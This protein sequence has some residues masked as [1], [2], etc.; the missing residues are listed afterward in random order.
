MRWH[1][2]LVSLKIVWFTLMLM[3]YVMPCTGQSHELDSLEQ[4]LKDTKDSPA[5]VQVLYALTNQYLLQ[6]GYSLKVIE[7]A[8]Q[9]C[10]LAHHLNDQLSIAYCW[11]LRGVIARNTSN[12][13]EA[14]EGHKKALEISTMLNHK[15]SMA[16]FLNNMGVVYR[17]VDDYQQALTFHLKALKLSE[18]IDDKPNISVAVNSIGNIYLSIKEWGKALNYLTKGLELETARSNKLGVAINL[19]NIGG[20]HENLGNF[21]KALTYYQQSLT[22]NTEM[23]NSKGIAICL[24]D[25]GNIY[26]KNNRPDEALVYYLQALEINSKLGD[27]V[28]ITDSY[29]NIGKVSSR[30]KNYTQSLQY[31]QKGLHTAQEVGSKKHIQLCFEAISDTYSQMGMHE[32][33]LQVYKKAIIYKDSLLNE[34]NAKN[35]AGLQAFFDNKKKEARIGVLE[36][37]KEDKEQKIQYQR[38]VTGVLVFGLLL[39]LVV[40]AFLYRNYHIRKRTNQ[41]LAYQN[42]AINLQKDEILR[43]KENIDLKNQELVLLNEE[44][45]HLIG[46]VAHDL[47]SPL[48]RMYGLTNLLK[49]DEKN[50][51]GEQKQY[52]QLISEESARLN[53]M[54]AKILDMNAIEQ[55]RINLKLEK[56]AVHQLIQETVNHIQPAAAKKQIRIHFSPST[57]KSFALLDWGYAIQILDNLLSNAVKFSPSG[58]QVYIDLQESTETIEITIVDEGPG[59]STEDQAK[60][61]GKFQKL[62]ARPTAGEP[63]TGLG[64]SIV[65]KYVEAMHGQIRCESTQGKGAKFI[66]SFKKYT[67]AETAVA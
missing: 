38:I 17:R 18:S 9:A 40:F 33:A 34:S 21:D 37:E 6:Q 1:R 22:L 30:L 65:K 32:Q 47:R 23:N 31:L 4:K 39:I 64:L 29:I 49:L 53:D 55:Q 28:Y 63:S 2:I 57:L 48:S 5:K 43:Q 12:Y 8:D 11:D 51:T 42:A 16:Q 27:Q 60:L 13:A 58:K 15:A 14:L 44:K 3:A 67:H 7:L 26:E 35:I 54:I 56:T 36:H 52:I 20:V 61:F 19:N 25:I 24:N 59:F 66:V 45:T 62:S 10:Q 46:I 50:L 41:I